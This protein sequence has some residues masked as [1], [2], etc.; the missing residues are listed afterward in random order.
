MVSLQLVNMRFGGVYGIGGIY[1]KFTW[2]FLLRFYAINKGWKSSLSPKTSLS[3]QGLVF[4][5]GQGLVLI[6]RPLIVAMNRMH[7]TPIPSSS[8]ILPNS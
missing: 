2:W 8:F 3:N 6:C 1:F 7:H 5:C 4:C